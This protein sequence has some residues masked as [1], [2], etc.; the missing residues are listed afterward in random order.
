MSLPVAMREIFDL[1][2]RYSYVYCLMESERAPNMS[3]YRRLLVFEHT[4]AYLDRVY[5]IVEG[6]SPNAAFYTR[7]DALRVF[8]MA[9][10]LVGVLNE[11][12]DFIAAG[13]TVSPPQVQP[14]KPLPPPLPARS[15]G[16]A[17]DNLQRSLDSIE[18]A[19]RTLARWGQRWQDSSSLQHA[20]DSSTRDLI[21]KL[22]IRQQMR[23]R[24]S[25][26]QAISPPVPPREMRWVDVDVEA[27]IRGNR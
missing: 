27:M 18:R 21:A 23:Q 25:P 22:R 1:E 4:I 24:A 6:G 9:T 19:N 8:F 16:H 13:V 14:G 20:L 3:N 15:G 17:V 5:G 12:E 11:A 26:P 7:D 2:L 10:K